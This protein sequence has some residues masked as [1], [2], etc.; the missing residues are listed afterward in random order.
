MVNTP[1]I[2]TINKHSNP[3]EGI[4]TT[5]SSDL[6]LQDII[7]TYMGKHW[8]RIQAVSEKATTAITNNTKLATVETIYAK[9]MSYRFTRQRPQEE[10]LFYK[11]IEKSILENRPIPIALGHGP[12]K[13]PNNVTSP[14][15]DW[16]EFFLLSQLCL[17]QQAI[18]PLYPPG[19]NYAL[20]L[21]DSRSAN[22][23][24]I[25]YEC[26]D[27]YRN[28]LQNLIWQCGLNALFPSI[29]SLKEFYIAYDVDKFLPEAEEIVSKW[30]NDP[31]H[32]YQMV[33]QFEHAKRNIPQVSSSTNELTSEQLAEIEFAAHQYRV[34][35]QAEIL[36]GIWSLPN[37]IYGRFS[38]HSNYWQL[39]TLRK[40]SVAQPWQGEG[41]LRLNHK[42]KPEPFLMTQQK[43]SKLKSLGSWNS[44][45]EL[46][47]FE[48]I[49]IFE[50]II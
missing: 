26:M 1:L 14:H 42:S 32:A 25:D 5:I 13:N 20:F 17:L 7:Q 11:C 8:K 41:C 33:Q 46:R 34:Y 9:L 29:I 2:N 36:S 37:F 31:K 50:D 21:D 24:G 43:R 4:D 40:G 38:Q 35:L 22:A 47:G 19:I 27:T 15:V 45:I 30:E 39:F 48:S 16:S 3:L 44:F 6:N 28:S 12:L 49:E 23:N 10:A 18:T